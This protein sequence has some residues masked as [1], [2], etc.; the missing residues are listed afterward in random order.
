MKAL[1]CGPRLAALL[2]WY[3]EMQS[4]LSNQ[5]MITIFSYGPDVTPLGDLTTRLSNATCL[6]SWKLLCIHEVSSLLS[7]GIQLVYTLLSIV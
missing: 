4:I 3:I 7:H 5:G 2:M 1:V 6:M